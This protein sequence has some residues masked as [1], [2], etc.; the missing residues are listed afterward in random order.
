MLAVSCDALF[1]CII[2]DFAIQS[3][4]DCS[5]QILG[6]SSSDCSILEWND[7]SH[8]PIRSLSAY[9]AVIIHPFQS[10]DISSG[11]INDSDWLKAC[12]SPN[13]KLQC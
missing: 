7:T 3:Q 9:S 8:D 12:R 4:T 13:V 11:M 10:G 2:A 6:F 5:L 1:A